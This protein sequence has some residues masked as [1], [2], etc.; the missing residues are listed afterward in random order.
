MPKFVGGT[1]EGVRQ[2]ENNA[3]PPMLWV[4]LT[5]SQARLMPR[6]YVVKSLDTTDRGAY[7]RYA[8]RWYRWFGYAPRVATSRRATPKMRSKALEV[9]DFGGYV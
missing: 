8:K 7:R 3:V 6:R 5:Y 1:I 4:R 9:L 2:I